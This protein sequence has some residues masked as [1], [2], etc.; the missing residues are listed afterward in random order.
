MKW[1]YTYRKVIRII[2]Y[3]KVTRISYKEFPYTLQPDSADVIILPHLLYLSIY[4]LLVFFSWPFGNKFQTWYSFTGKYLNEYFLKTTTFRKLTLTQYFY[5][6]Y[7]PYSNFGNCPNN[8]L[9]SRSLMMPIYPIVGDFNCCIEVVLAR[10]LHCKSLKIISLKYSRW[11]FYR[12]F[13]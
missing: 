3:K 1:F 8:I 12:N 13:Y 4:M 6:I 10:F 9:D 2:Y 7:R 5:Q 11:K